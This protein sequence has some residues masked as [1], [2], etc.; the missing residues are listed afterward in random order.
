MPFV[1]R[2]DGSD[3]EKPYC[4]YTQGEGGRRHGCVATEEQ[5]KKFQAA[6]YANVPEARKVMGD[7]IIHPGAAVKAMGDGKVGGYLVQYGSEA[8]K[9]A[10]GEWFTPETDFDSEF[11][12]RVSI[13]WNHGLDKTIGR[14][15]LA[16]GTMKADDLG[17]WVEAQLNMADRYQAEMYRMAAAGKLGWSSGSLAHLTDP[18]RES[19]GGAIKNWALGHD[20]SLTPMPADRRNVAIAL[21]SWDPPPFEELAVEVPTCSLN[22]AIERATDTVEVLT[23]DLRRHAVKAGRKLSHARRERLIRLRDELNDMLSETEPLDAAGEEGSPSLVMGEGAEAGK[24]RPEV[25][26]MPPLPDLHDLYAAMIR[27]EDRGLLGLPS[28]PVPMGT[29][30]ITGR[31]P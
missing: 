15:R 27:Q 5:A 4:V 9:D 10:D 8:T 13:H 17:V 16:H 28:G 19:P 30:P 22:E 14:R 1:I 26:S 3:P 25:I 31:Y 6:L 24:D 18:P 21:K 23:G 7:Y 12:A 2:K 11:P 29:L 20:A